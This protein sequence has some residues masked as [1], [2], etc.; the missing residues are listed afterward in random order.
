MANSN[1]KLQVK[2]SGQ[3]L[4]IFQVTSEEGR[5]ACQGVLP[6]TENFLWEMTNAPGNPGWSLLQVKS[7][8]LYL[9]VLNNALTNGAT[10]GQNTLVNKNSA[11]DNFLWQIIAAP[12][13]P[14]WSLIK[15]KST[16]QYLNIDNGGNNNGTPACQGTLTDLNNLPSNFLWQEVTSNSKP[17]TVNLQIDCPSVYALQEGPLSVA[18]ADAYLVFSDDN[19]GRKET[20]N[21]TSFESFVN[22]GSIV[23]WTASTKSGRNNA[24]DVSIDAIAYDIGT[25]TGDVFTSGLTK[26]NGF[27]TAAV[28][29]TAIGPDEGDNEYYTVNFTISPKGGFNAG[30]SKS[31]SVDPRMRVK[32]TQ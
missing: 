15:V 2:S 21:Q 7:S 19:N 27:V 24:Y 25:G 18:Q 32:A 11:P 12:N 9:N 4:N 20:G 31:Y 10:V 30:P 23:K 8:G 3:F 22:P 26:G 5:Y 13:N 6:T 17:V 14:G 1:L 28:S 29:W 16:N